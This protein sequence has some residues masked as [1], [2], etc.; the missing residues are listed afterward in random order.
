MPPTPGR[1]LSPW[2][3]SAFDCSRSVAEVADLRTARHVLD[4][5]SAEPDAGDAS[6][7]VVVACRHDDDDWAQMSTENVTRAPIGRGL[8][9]FVHR[10][11]LVVYRVP[12]SL[13]KLST[14][15]F[16]GKV[17]SVKP[18]LGLVNFVYPL[19]GPKSLFATGSVRTVSSEGEV[20]C[21]GAL[22][23]ETYAGTRSFV[24]SVP[25]RKGNE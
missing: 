3:R 12:F 10:L 21:A 5:E 11:A 7:V 8:V 2:P 16:L 14:D 4:G 15:F 20:D 1:P 17:T 6:D 25:S 13:H 9:N 23:V 24:I 22:Q 18:V 19:F